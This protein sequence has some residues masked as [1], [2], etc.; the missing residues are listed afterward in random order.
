MFG[1]GLPEW[2][3]GDLSTMVQSNGN[4]RRVYDPL[5]SPRRGGLDQFPNNVMPQSR[6]DPVANKVLSCVPNANR[7]GR[8][9]PTGYGH[10]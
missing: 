1:V 3:T 2:K 8:W 10:R 4:L 6:V 7:C 9:P 5:T